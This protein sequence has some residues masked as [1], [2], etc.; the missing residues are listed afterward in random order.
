M[1]DN[2]SELRKYIN[3]LEA[4]IEALEKS[5]EERMHNLSDKWFKRPTS[6][7]R[8]PKVGDKQAERELRLVLMGPPGAGTL[9]NH[10]KCLLCLS[11]TNYPFCREGYPIAEN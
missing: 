5:A 10:V 7:H 6:E 9:N 3:K 11:D 4:R 8:A 2:E 1:P